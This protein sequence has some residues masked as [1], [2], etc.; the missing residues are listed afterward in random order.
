MTPA[1][2]DRG[3]GERAT[4]QTG[5]RPAIEGVIRG[6]YALSVGNPGDPI[7]PGWT[8]TALTSVARLE[9]GHT[10]SRRHPEYWDGDV[11]WIGIRDATRNHGRTLSDTAQHTNELGIAKSSARVLPA[12][13]VCLSR[14]A[15]VGYV[16]VMGR[17][18]AT[19]QDFVNWVC[20]P[21]LDHRFLKYIL[22]AEHSTFLSFA[23]GTTHQTIYFPEVKAFHVCLPSLDLQRR[24][25]DVLTEMDDLIENNRRRIELLEEMSRVIYREW[26]VHFRYPGHETAAVVNSP[27]GPIPETWTIAPVEE[28]ASVEKGLSY[29]GAY[30]TQA[31]VPMANLKCLRPGGG[32]RRDGTKPYSGPHKPRH[33]VRPGDLVMANTDLTQAGTV[34]GSPAFVP[35]RGFE[36]GGIISHHL[37]AIRCEDQSRIHWLYESFRDERFRAYARGV[38]S[39]ATVLGFRPA[40]LLAYPLACPP[41][42]LLNEFATIRSELGTLIEDLE[43]S[44]ETLV[45]LRD[46]L[47][48]KLVT[49]QVDVSTLDLGSVLEGA[50]G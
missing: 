16:V 49:G 18:M 32:F 27:A 15:S 28:L 1:G 7:A 20:S 26:F 5:G 2:E 22:L 39:G 17:E 43:D 13:T 4:T 25:A 6:R 50:A 11:P 33:E 21:Q 46:L 36:D 48:P 23:S 40:D 31:G 38:A 24:I 45:T 12:D 41:D 44:I 42:R 3:T 19:S 35:R 29:K 9:S 8:W 14:T 10:P 30:L 47:L 37:F 34:I